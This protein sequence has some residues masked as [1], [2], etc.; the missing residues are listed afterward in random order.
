MIINPVVGET[1]R[2]KSGGNP[3]NK[4]YWHQLATIIAVTS[5]DVTYRF[6]DGA[7]RNPSYPNGITRSLTSFLNKFEGPMPAL[8]SGV[9]SDGATAT[10]AVSDRDLN[11]FLGAPAPVVPTSNKKSCSVCTDDTK[12]LENGKCD[13]CVTIKKL[14]A[15]FGQKYSKQDYYGIDLDPLQ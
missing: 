4:K 11:E 1:W 3:N 12:P 15:K 7:I 6:V 13:D 14:I 5:L 8:A 2:F 9:N 10:S